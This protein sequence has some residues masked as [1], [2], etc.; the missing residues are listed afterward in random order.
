MITSIRV[1]RPGG[2]VQSIQPVDI[3]PIQVPPEQLRERVYDLN[4]LLPDP[5]PETD[6][7]KPKFHQDGSI[8]YVRREGNWEPPAPVEGYRA[9][10]D[11]RWLM[12][13]I[14]PICSQRLYGLLGPRPCGC[15]GVVG[16]CRSQESPTPQ[17]RVTLSNC[18]ACP[19]KGR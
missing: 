19:L 1:V 11:N 2:I 18:E 16:F 15:I 9:D 12:R 7:D 3:K 14:W 6:F 17:Q 13:P 8:E 4:L 10:P 5:W